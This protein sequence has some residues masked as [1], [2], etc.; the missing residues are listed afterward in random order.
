MRVVQEE[1]NGSERKVVVEITKF[2][3]GAVFV[4]AILKTLKQLELSTRY[5]LLFSYSIALKSNCVSLQVYL[6]DEK[7]QFSRL[8]LSGRYKI[9][10]D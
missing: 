7:G 6:M 1:G 9:L 2:C 4:V 8:A 10:Q 3:P 5:N